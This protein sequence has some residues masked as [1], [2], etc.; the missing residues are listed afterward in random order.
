MLIY[1]RNRNIILFVPILEIF[2]RAYKSNAVEDFM[3]AGATSEQAISLHPSV[4]GL[5]GCIYGQGIKTLCSDLRAVWA[6]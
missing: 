3:L 6:L 1:N 4:T 2:W 5:A